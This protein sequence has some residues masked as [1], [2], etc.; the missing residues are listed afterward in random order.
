[1]GYSKLSTKGYATDSPDK[2]E[3]SL[4]IPGGSITMEDVAFPIKGTDNRGYTQIMHPGRNYTFPGA[5]YVIEV[6]IKEGGTE[7]F[8][9]K[10]F[11]KLK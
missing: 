2:D 8:T 1:M 11:T 9:K 6:P 5:A 10:H 4:M 7:P 3:S